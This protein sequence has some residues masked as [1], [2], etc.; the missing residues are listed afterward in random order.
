[1][2]NRRRHVH[3]PD[4]RVTNSHDT[5]CRLPCSIL[6]GTHDARGKRAVL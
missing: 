1:V 4:I 2:A 3:H 6:Y 5:H